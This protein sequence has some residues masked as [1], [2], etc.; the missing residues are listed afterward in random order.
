M[1]RSSDSQ[2]SP[3]S[4]AATAMNDTPDVVSLYRLAEAEE[5]PVYWYIMDSA[6]ESVVVELSPGQTAIALDPLK[7]KDLGDEKYKLAHELGHSLTGSLYRRDTPLDEKG[8]N[9]QRADRWAIEHL[10]PF[11][12]LEAAVRDGRT[13]LSELAELFQLPQTLIEKAVAYYTG[14]CGLTL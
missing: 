10:L 9:E 3:G 8:R 11:S 13:R 5:V 12:A 1:R 6:L 14:P 2:N 4:R 7:F